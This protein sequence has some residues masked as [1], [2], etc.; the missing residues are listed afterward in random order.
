MMF[1]LRENVKH[2]K[3]GKSFKNLS[4]L[5]LEPIVK[6]DEKEKQIELTGYLVL[7]GEFQTSGIDWEKQVEESD[8]IHYGDFF[9]KRENQNFQYQIPISFDIHPDRVKDSS[10][11]FVGVENFDY[12][13][14]SDQE[15]EL[16]VN[17]KLIGVHP[18]QQQEKPEDLKF[19]NNVKQDFT[20]DFM[21][22]DDGQVL[23]TRKEEQKKVT[24]ESSN[25][26]LSL[27]T[28]KEKGFAVEKDSTVTEKKLLENVKEQE[29][30][31]QSY[32]EVKETEAIKAVSKDKETVSDSLEQKVEENLKDSKMKIGIKGKS[33]ESKPKGETE[34]KSPLYSLLKKDR[35]KGKIEEKQA[36]NEANVQEKPVTEGVE[37][38]ASKTKEVFY[39]QEE[40]DN[41]EEDNTVIS[42][43][44]YIEE[45]DK[46][47]EQ[48]EEQL[49]QQTGAKTTTSTSKTKDILFSLLKGNEGTNRYKLKIY[50]V[51]KNES[52]EQ[53]ADKYSIK[54]S[55]I[56]SYNN[57]D[58]QE[59][60]EGQLLYLPRKG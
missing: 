33:K 12:K 53:I 27:N 41:N 40:K 56:L 28:E 19:S 11:V 36:E 57:L 59:V 26:Q 52:L 45:K 43:Q 35:D 50:L 23:K 54:T 18:D 30:E 44:E 29:K 46:E 15:M 10:N 31:T 24:E 58:S 7:N 17:V 39:Q 32:Q 6:V 13:V 60:K 38:E 34:S 21:Y 51:Q 20:S 22:F 48:S 2:F 49:E 14:I 16:I 47:I 9:E 5:E 4:S 3:D 55:D 42:M 37:K 8:G 25:E 1:E